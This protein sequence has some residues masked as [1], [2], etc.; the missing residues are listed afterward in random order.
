MQNHRVESIHILLCPEGFTGYSEMWTVSPRNTGHTEKPS[1]QEHCRGFL[2]RVGARPSGPC[3]G[4]PLFH[5]LAVY[6][7][8]NINKPLGNH[9]PN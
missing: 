3:P 5:I 6:F 7:Q 1:A 4:T 2:N 9:K 8:N